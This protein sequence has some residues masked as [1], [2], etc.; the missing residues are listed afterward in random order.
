MVSTRENFRKKKTICTSRFCILTKNIVSHLK[1]VIL[2][3]SSFTSDQT[4]PTKSLHIWTPRFLVSFETLVRRSA[5]LQ[6]YKFSVKAF[7]SSNYHGLKSDQG[8]VQYFACN[9]AH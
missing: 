2:I 8:V 9:P 4:I 5:I 3:C 1:Q 7:D 6:L